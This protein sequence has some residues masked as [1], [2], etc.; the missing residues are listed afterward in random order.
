M[1]LEEFRVPQIEYDAGAWSDR[2][3]ESSKN[4]AVR[5]G[6]EMSEAL[7]HHDHCIELFRRGLIIADLGDYVVWPVAKFACFC[8]RVI[9]AINSGYRIPAV[10]KCTRVPPH[11]ATHIQNFLK[12]RQ[13]RA[14]ADK[15]RF[16]NSP[17]FVDSSMEELNPPTRLK[18]RYCIHINT[19]T[20]Q[21]HN[22][23]Y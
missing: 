14:R 19:S 10:R 12:F 20:S 18:I 2:V 15:F 17:R 11:S 13:R 9:V 1:R 8:D 7:T 16:P 23:L 6:I 3:R 4:I 22:V 5:S 21:P